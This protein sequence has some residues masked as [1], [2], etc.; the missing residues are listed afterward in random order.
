MPRRWMALALV[1]CLLA[2]CL[3]DGRFPDHDE[4]QRAEYE[5]FRGVVVQGHLTGGGGEVAIDAFARND[6]PITYKV[7]SVCR[8][9]WTDAMEGRLG[10]VHPHGEVGYC[11]AFGLRDFPP[12][13]SIPFHVEWNGT[14]W[15]LQDG[16]FVQ[17]PS[18]TYTWHLAFE[19]YG[20]CVGGS[21]ELHDS[22]KLRFTVTVD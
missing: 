3:A 9:P 1:G 7:S 16:R 22:I 14:L 11:H 2:G 8:P 5:N 4:T 19:G 12:G 10:T 18:G 15:D 17:A 13:E 6:G 20:Q 21:C